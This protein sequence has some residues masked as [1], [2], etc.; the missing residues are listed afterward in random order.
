[1]AL[2][3]IDYEGLRPILLV[4]LRVPIVELRKTLPAAK[5][6]VSLR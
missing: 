6:D 2:L 5:I 4:P 3:T 1:M